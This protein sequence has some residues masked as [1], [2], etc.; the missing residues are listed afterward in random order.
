MADMV[1]VFDIDRVTTKFGFYE[2]ELAAETK[3][4][5]YVNDVLNLLYEINRNSFYPHPIDVQIVSTTTRFLVSYP[6]ASSTRICFIS[7]F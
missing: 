4:R 3:L 6:N 1:T 2:L 7:V 5:K